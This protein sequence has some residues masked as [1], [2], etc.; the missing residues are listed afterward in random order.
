MNQQ[1]LNT[2]RTLAR[3]RR[4]GI[5]TCEGAKV[6]RHVVFKEGGITAARSTDDSERLGEC[7]LRQ[8]CIT[9]QHLRDATLF[10]R[11]GRRL[12]EVLA[13]LHIIQPAEIEE[14]VRM[15]IME[16]ASNVLIQPPKRMAFSST[17]DVIQVVDKAVMVLDVIMEA[18][19]RTPQIEDHLKKLLEDDRHL[20]LTKDS[21]V[22]MERVTMKPHEAFILSRITGSEPTRSVFA[23]SPLSEEQTARAVL[24]HLYVGILELRETATTHGLAVK[25]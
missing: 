7:L 5:L 10:A 8:G 25:A 20:S 15:Q 12:G 11:K 16:V 3:E 19:R 1:V 2:L 6:S 24:G 9:E 4:T 13:D 17:K 22:L 21:M 14:Y 23:L 18:A